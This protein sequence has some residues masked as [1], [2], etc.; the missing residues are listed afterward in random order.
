MAFLLDTNVLSEL[1]RDSRCDPRVYAWAQSVGSRACYISV[2][3]LGEIR[4]G[5]EV[6]R[7]RSPEQVPAFEKWI[8]K[9]T[10]DYEDFILP[11]T[12]EVAGQ[13]GRLNAIQSLPVIDGLIA[14]TAAHF[15][16]TI[17]TRNLNDFPDAIPKLNPWEFTP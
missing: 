16:L 2:L 5:I 7:R 12:E 4:K 15:R 8:D 9:L 3:S 17:V 10:R 1:R 11:V 6:L 14:A 13:W